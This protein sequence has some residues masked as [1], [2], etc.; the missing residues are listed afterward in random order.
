MMR[1]IWAVLMVTV[2]VLLLSVAGSAYAQSTPAPAPATVAPPPGDKGSCK[3]YPGL[4]NRIA[5][6]VRK[7]MEDAATQYFKGFYK[8]VSLAITAFMTL[9]LIIYG[10]MAASGAL[11]RVGMDTIYLLMKIAFVSYLTTNTDVM[12]KQVIT[13]MDATAEAAVRYTPGAGVVAQAGKTDFSQVNCLKNMRGAND[14]SG[15]PPSG[16]WLGMDCLLDSVIGIKVSDAGAAGGSIAGTKKWYNENLSPKDWGLSRGLLYVFFS[17]MTTSVVGAIFAVIGFIFVYG[18][19]FLIVKTLFVYL[20][21]YIGI[22]FLMIIS[23]LFLPLVLI[24]RTR[25]YFDKWVKLVISFALQ[26]V[27]ML[28]FV[29]MT[30]TAVDL[31]AFSADY[32]VMY[33]LAGDA[34]RQKDFSLNSYLLKVRNADGAE[35]PSADDPS[36]KGADGNNNCGSSIV[37]E[38]KVAA[39]IKANSTDPGKGTCNTSNTAVKGICQSVCTK[40]KTDKNSPKY[41]ESI[42]KICAQS[43]PL[44]VW[45][46]AIDWEKLAKAR[47]PAVQPAEG[48]TP[49][50][51]IARECLSAVIFCGIVV[52]VMNGLIKIVPIVA[53]DLL[54]DF[55]QSPNVA[56]SVGTLGRAS[57]GKS[58]TAAT[59]GITNALK[60]ILGAPK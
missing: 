49:G 13:L 41:D 7:T 39:L 2:A 5:S 56:A 33:R 43:Y 28:I 22:A 59:S 58:V 18:L 15:E 30:I 57:I 37:K 8:L 40:A 42:A 32:S 38:A 26:P 16:P 44:Q 53:Y 35:V 6:C 24:P 54:G 36:C 55:G 4:T 23:P 20:A 27:I 50:Q 52:F 11:E 1:G 9:A 46:N 21:S 48:A 12:Y 3:Q 45:H 51:Q 60:G 47:T 14:A 17:G 25:E 31:A 34:S 10:I 19:V 29:S